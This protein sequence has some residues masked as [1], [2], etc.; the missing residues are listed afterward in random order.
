MHNVQVIVC[1]HPSL[2]PFIRV[3]FLTNIEYFDGSH[4]DGSSLD[5]RVGLGSSIL[6]DRSSL[7]A[8][9]KLE[10]RVRRFKRK[11]K[12]KKFFAGLRVK[13][14]NW[15]LEIKRSLLLLYLP[16][17][18]RTGIPLFSRKLVKQ[19]ILVSGWAFNL[20][21]RGRLH[22]KEI[23]WNVG[24]WFSIKD[25]CSWWIGGRCW[26]GRRWSFWGRCFYFYE[27][28]NSRLGVF[29]SNLLVIR[30]FLLRFGLFFSDLGFLGCR[31]FM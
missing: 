8:I 12:K 17:I 15:V 26:L 19:W 22:I 25:Q 13:T 31:L 20:W 21:R 6:R 27:F 28:L 29:S 18:L 3:F 14:N 7:D 11:I 9:Y 5:N 16:M 1:F 23:C 4:L 30:L 2:P 24:G 10:R